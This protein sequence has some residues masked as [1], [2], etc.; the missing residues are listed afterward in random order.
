MGTAGFRRIFSWGN[1]ID[2][3]H[4]NYDETGLGATSA[5][6]CFPRGLSPY[7]CEDMAGNVWEWCQDWFAEEYYSK[8]PK[9]N[10]PGSDT[11]S[12]RVRRGGAWDSSAAVCRSAF[13]RGGDPGDRS[14]YLGFRLLRT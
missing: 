11:G 9:E 2:P 7:G 6:G 3:E 5:V 1:E 13:R 8:S 14:A 10:P 12:G 4:A